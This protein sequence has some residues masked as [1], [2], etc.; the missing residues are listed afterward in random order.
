MENNDEVIGL[1]GII[2]RYLRHWKLFLIVFILSFIP[3]ILYLVFYPRTYEFKTRIQIQ[4]EQS[5]GGASLAMGEA[6]G[7]MKSFG[8]GGGSAGS[9]SIDDE[10]SIQTLQRWPLWTMNTVS[11][12][13]STPGRLR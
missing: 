10:M 3:A 4:E 13:R 1:K 2:V 8:I 6:A 11:R 7:L 9:I 5:L 12:C